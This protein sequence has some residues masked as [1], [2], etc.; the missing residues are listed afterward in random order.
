VARKYTPTVRQ[1]DSPT[2]IGREFGVTCSQNQLNKKPERALQD[3]KSGIAADLA[4]LYWQCGL[5]P[6]VVKQFDV[7]DLLQ[8][9]S[10]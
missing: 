8:R 3:N 2:V 6:R 10:N 9:G 1:L 4:R 5:L 7:H